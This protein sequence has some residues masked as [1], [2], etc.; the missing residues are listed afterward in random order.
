MSIEQQ[1][2]KL[3]HALSP[4]VIC[5]EGNVSGKKDDTFII[6]SSGTSLRSLTPD[7]LTTCCLNTARKISGKKP[8]MEASFHAWLL[9]HTDINFIAHT[10]PLNV[11]KIV[12]S[13]ILE[14]FATKRLFPDQVIFNGAKSCIVPYAKPGTSLAEQ[15]ITQ[16]K[17]FIHKENIFPCVIL[18]QNHGLICCGNTIKNCLYSTMMCEKA[19][20]IFIGTHNISKTHYLSELC[21]Q[22]LLNDEQEKYRKQLIK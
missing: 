3:A 1:L 12:C 21:V 8:S 20:E 10:H 17:R 4:Y 18:L 19:A 15:I 9:Q 5:A 6:K 13:N 14:D 11:L 22:E 7:S 2:I 16:V